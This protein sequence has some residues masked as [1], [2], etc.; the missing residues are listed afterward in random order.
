MPFT[1]CGGTTRTCAKLLPSEVDVIG[2]THR[3]AYFPCSEKEDVTFCCLKR[4]VQEGFMEGVVFA[5]AW[6]NGLILQA[7]VEGRDF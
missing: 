7:E 2:V 3:V 6:G 4:G 5:R 1:P